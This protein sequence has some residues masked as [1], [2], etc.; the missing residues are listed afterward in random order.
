ME[1][2]FSSVM[3][4]GMNYTGARELQYDHSFV[5]PCIKD[6]VDDTVASRYMSK[7]SCSSYIG[8]VRFGCLLKKNTEVLS[9]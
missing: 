5:E 4:S 9:L 7:Q 8:N 1:H 2:S 3:K 6:I